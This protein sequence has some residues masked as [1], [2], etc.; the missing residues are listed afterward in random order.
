[1]IRIFYFILC[2]VLFSSSTLSLAFADTVPAANNY[3]SSANSEPNTSSNI[4]NTLNPN[5][6]PFQD[7][8]INFSGYLDGSYNRL[9]GNGFFING[10]PDRVF[11]TKVNGFTLQQAAVT[12]ANQPDQGLGG[13]VNIIT[14]NDAGPITAYNMNSNDQFD[15]TQAFLQYATGPVTFMAGKYVTLAGVETIDPTQDTNFSRS[16]LFGY[17][18]P[19]TQTGIRVIYKINKIISLK[20]GINNG[21]D[22]IV[23]NNAGNYT[24]E[25]GT[26]L[27]PID[28]FTLSAVD[29]N[30]EARV[31]GLVNTGPLGNRNLIDLIAN[32]KGTTK[33]T[34][35][36]N[37][38]RGTQNNA[39]FVDGNIGT[40]IWDGIAGYINYQL[41]KKWLLSLRSEYFNDQDGYRTGVEQQW[42]EATFSVGYEPIKCLEFRAEVRKDWSNENAFVD[43]NGVTTNTNQASVGIEGIFKF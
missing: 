3:T 19:Y 11:D 36:L 8:G 16:I 10:T 22:N 12:L 7:L 24:L 39:T 32:L 41:T 14:G 31:N 30:G 26:T 13:L 4:V 2:L 15:V 40:A 23:N 5:F 20:L 42:K 27:T 6:Q 33:L 9:S 21:W 25:L 18:T 38:D 28:W 35:V 1:M 43:L 17:A 37:Y 34:Y 29:Y